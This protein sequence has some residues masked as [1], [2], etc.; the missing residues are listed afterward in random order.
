MLIEELLSRIIKDT[1][2][3]LCGYG[4]ELSYDSTFS[5]WK[6]MIKRHYT[7]YTSSF[8]FLLEETK[9]IIPTFV[10]NQVSKVENVYNPRKIYNIDYESLTYKEPELGKSEQEDII[11]I[12]F[13]HI[14]LIS[15]YGR[16][17]TK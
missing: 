16:R 11:N 9:D 5:I 10:N 8:R 3:L 13:E 12:N 17:T 7:N 14:K 6:S 4:E 2:R 15:F 1:N